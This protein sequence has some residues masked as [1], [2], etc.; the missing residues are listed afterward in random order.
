MDGRQKGNIGR[1]IKIINESCMIMRLS[2]HSFE[3]SS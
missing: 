1:I 2:L 3:L